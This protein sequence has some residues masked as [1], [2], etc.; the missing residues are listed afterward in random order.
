MDFSEIIG[1]IGLIL[2][3]FIIFI[4]FCNY[5]RRYDICSI[6]ICSINHLLYG[7][8]I[9]TF[10]LYVI[11][12]I[13][14]LIYDITRH[15]LYTHFYDCDGPTALL[16]ICSM[17]NHVICSINIFYKHLIILKLYFYNFTFYSSSYSFIIPPTS[18]RQFCL[19]GI[20]AYCETKLNIVF[21]TYQVFLPLLLLSCLSV[22]MNFEELIKTCNLRI[23]QKKIP[24]FIVK[25]HS[26]I[27]IKAILQCIFRLQSK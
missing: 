27:P 9:T 11:C 14:Q 22:M 4:Y 8:Q 13:R 2:Q 25:L 5:L 12:S 16:N 6:S 21:T 7:S 23:F 15:L 26:G 18:W 1:K 19:S 3:L 24:H 17:S 20:C 10:A